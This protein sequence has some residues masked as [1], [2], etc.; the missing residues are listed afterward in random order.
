MKLTLT[1]LECFYPYVDKTCEDTEIILKSFDK[2]L[3]YVNNC[4]GGDYRINARRKIMDIVGDT[5]NCA[6]DE[7][8]AIVAPR[9][10]KK[11]YE[12]T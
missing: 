11:N 3:P 9:I 5:H 8:E 10:R 1:P 2:N 4:A 12:K 6:V 7:A